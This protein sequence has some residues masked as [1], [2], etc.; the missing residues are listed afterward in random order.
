MD[1]LTPESKQ[2]MS[3]DLNNYRKMEALRVRDTQKERNDERERQIEK[4]RKKLHIVCL[5]YNEQ[6]RI[7][8]KTKERKYIGRQ[9][10]NQ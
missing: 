2:Y 5:Q 6:E 10:I 4:Y 1:L 3:D 7:R 8:E 9:M